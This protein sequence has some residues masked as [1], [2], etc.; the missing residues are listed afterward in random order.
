M[1]KGFDCRACRRNYAENNDPV[2]CDT[3]GLE[4]C[5]YWQTHGASPGQELTPI[6]RRAIHWLRLIKRHGWEQVMGL[7]EMAVTPYEASYLLEAWGMYED[8]VQEMTQRS[9]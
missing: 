3:G 5:P 1:F 7:V 2:P 4:A 8:F 9:R 6:N